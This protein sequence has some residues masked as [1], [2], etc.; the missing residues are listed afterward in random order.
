MEIADISK[1]IGNKRLIKDS[2]EINIIE[3]ACKISANAHLEAMKFVKPGMNEAEVEAF[4]YMS[5]LKMVEDFQPII[6]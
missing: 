1:I 2:S 6:Q 5:L 3:K 4:T